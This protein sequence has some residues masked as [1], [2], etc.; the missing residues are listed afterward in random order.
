MNGPY[1]FYALKRDGASTESESS[2]STSS[3]SSPAEEVSTKSRTEQKEEEKK[4]V[5]IRFF[6]INKL[7][8]CNS[9]VQENRFSDAIFIRFSPD[10]NCYRM[11]DRF[12]T[13]FHRFSEIFHNFSDEKNI[14]STNRL[15]FCTV[16]F[17]PRNIT[18]WNIGNLRETRHFFW[19]ELIIPLE[20]YEVATTTSL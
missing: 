7:L 16:V 8:I 10:W 3:S 14:F 5:S 13:N 20:P 4:K 12:F 1:P 15:H 17:L 2:S 18:E 6:F 9:R 11:F 19:L